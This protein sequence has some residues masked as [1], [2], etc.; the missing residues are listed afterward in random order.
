MPHDW[1]KS[2]TILM[3]KNKGD[4]VD[5]STYRLIRLMGHTLNIFERVLE[6]RLRAI[7]GLPSNR[8]CKRC[9]HPMDKNDLSRSYEP[10]T[11][12]AGQSKLFRIK[13]GVRQGSVPSPLPFITVMDAV[14]EGLKR[15]P[16]APCMQ[17]MW[18]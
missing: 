12:A 10:C 4:I 8:I 3:W 15:H 13:T 9:T 6:I 7:I 11:N 18:C 5:C 2:T 1:S 17:T 14:T 16:W